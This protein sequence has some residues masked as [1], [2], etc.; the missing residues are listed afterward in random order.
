MAQKPERR[1]F[2]TR[3][4]HATLFAFSSRLS[5]SGSGTKPPPVVVYWLAEA[6]A[7]AGGGGGATGTA[8]RARPAMFL[9]SRAA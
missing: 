4:F 8:G 3:S 9:I 6:A 2:S 7:E 5:R 1:S